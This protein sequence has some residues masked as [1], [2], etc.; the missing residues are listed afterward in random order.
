MPEHL[1]LCGGAEQRPPRG[2]T[3]LRLHLQGIGRNVTLRIEDISRKL[4]ADVPDLLTDLVELAAYVYAA[5]R[6]ISR[7]GKALRGMGRDWR[8]EMRFVVPVRRP[9]RWSSPE[10]QQSLVEALNF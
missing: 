7:G 10:V 4:V 9:E 6:S 3:P 2:T 5:D 8:R 1:V